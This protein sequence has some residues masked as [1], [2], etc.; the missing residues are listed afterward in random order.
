MGSIEERAAQW[1]IETQYWDGLGRH[2]VVEPEVLARLL[3]IFASGGPLPS[4]EVDLAGLIP[5]QA[6]QAG[7][8]KMWMLAVQLYGVR[9]RRN[10]GHGDFTDLL[11][12]IELAAQLGASGIGLNP[13]HA[14]FD[15]SADAYS[16]YSPS[17]RHFLISHY[18]DPENIAEVP[19][20]AA[21]G[22]AGEIA[23][24]RDAEL[25]DYAGLIKT[26]SRALELAYEAFRLSGSAVAANGLRRL[27][28][29]LRRTAR[30]LFLFRIPAPTVRQYLVDMAGRMAQAE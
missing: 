4:R 11:G 22:L 6:Y 9:S 7:T 17:S 26:K 28:E 10:W 25:V 30:P 2:R 15:E 13:L 23:A 19:G 21:A 16:P 24:L 12:L 29:T 5:S 3:D 8:A 18:I 14:L 1:G 27:P 20:V